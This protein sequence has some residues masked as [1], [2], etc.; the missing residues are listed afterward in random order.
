MPVWLVAVL[1]FGFGFGLARFCVP[2][3]EFGGF[4][5]GRGD[6]YRLPDSVLV[7]SSS[8]DNFWQAQIVK[9]PAA[10]NLYLALVHKSG[11]R[12]IVDT[13]F[14][15]NGYHAPVVRLD[16]SEGGKALKIGVDHDFGDG[17]LKFLFQMDK[18]RLERIR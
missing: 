2:G 3:G 7:Q 8:P 18:M 13:V 5:S 14:I 6:P 17:N 9:S 11:H 1:A 15:P 16:W 10:P 4:L 12:V